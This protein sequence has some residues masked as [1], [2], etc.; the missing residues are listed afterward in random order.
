MSGI[1]TSCH[2]VVAQGGGHL[3][4]LDSMF[5]G[6]EDAPLDP[7]ADADDDSSRGLFSWSSSSVTTWAGALL[8][9]MSS[10]MHSPNGSFW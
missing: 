9:S 7:E 4:L 6:T 1:V 2:A 3:N 8:A 10:D 5:F